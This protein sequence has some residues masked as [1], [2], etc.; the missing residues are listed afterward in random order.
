M[1]HGSWIMDH[2]SWILD[3]GSW[4]LDHGS[5]IMDH[6]SWIMDHGSWIMDR[7][8]WIMDHGSWIVDRGSWIVDRGSWIMDHGSWIWIMDH[9]CI[10]YCL[11][12]AQF[13]A[14]DSY[15]SYY[16]THLG[17]LIYR[18][19]GFYSMWIWQHVPDFVSL[20]IQQHVPEVGLKGLHVCLSIPAV[21]NFAGLVDPAACA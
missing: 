21:T 5:W 9:A 19:Y 17:H 18:A 13:A 10:A 3:I 2:G 11:E 8:S 15:E 14:R 16:Y 4:I 20:L 1:D 12:L 6:G 7:G